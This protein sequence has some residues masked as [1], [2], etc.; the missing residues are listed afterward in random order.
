MT[1][2]APTPN[3]LVNQLAD[4]RDQIR[5]KNKELKAL[6]IKRDDLELNLI[7]VMDN[8]VGTDQLRTDTITATITERVVG[9]IEDY[10]AF[11]RFMTR[12]KAFYLLE[13]RISTSAF[14]ELLDSRKGKAIPG[15]AS[16]T[17][18]SIGL[19]TRR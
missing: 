2:K 4:L 13:R 11:I 8:E 14:R 9:Q 17:K 16:F 19:R 1:R 6:K 5:D 15:L 18:R 3:D 10:D 7:E 12:N